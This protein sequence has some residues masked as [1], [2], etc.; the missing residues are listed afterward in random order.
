MRK[1]AFRYVEKIEVPPG[2]AAA[3]GTRVH[4]AAERYLTYAFI[5]LTSE[6]GQILLPGLQ[7]LPP[8][9]YPGMQ[10]EH[11][12]GTQIG[13]TLVRGIIDCWI[14]DGPMVIDHKT[15]GNLHWAKTPEELLTD[16]QAN[17][18]AFYAAKETGASSVSLRWVYYSTKAPFRAV[19]TDVVLDADHLAGIVDDI[20]SRGRLIEL[21]LKSNLRALDYPPNLEACGAYGGCPYRSRCNFSEEDKA[22]IRMNTMSFEEQL[23]AKLQ[24]PTP[25]GVILPPPAATPAPETSV[26]SPPGAVPQ[27]SPPPT[28]WTPSNSREE[29]VA[30]YKDREEAAVPTTPTQAVDAVQQWTETPTAGGPGK[31]RRTKED[32]ARDVGFTLY[33]GCAP[34]TGTC[35]DFA[36]R[37]RRIQDL[38]AQ[39]ANDAQAVEHDVAQHPPVGALVIDMRHPLANA[40]LPVLQTKADMT[41]RAFQ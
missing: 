33:V 17:V 19:P 16:T 4:G 11:K 29:A 8:P 20:D 32:K 39:G 27:V 6:E 18:Y 3:K 24:S 1:W 7:Y 21:S 35:E 23:K 41:V 34:T 40:A 14:P 28:P 15:T 26:W 36:T 12:F 37:V 5:D 31:K 10:L 30:K 9:M 22:E 25:K 2:P 13:D 38:I